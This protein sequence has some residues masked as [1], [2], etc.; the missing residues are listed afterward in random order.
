M[1]G[2]MGTQFDGELHN[3]AEFRCDVE[4]WMQAQKKK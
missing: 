4:V 2:G 3:G 1:C